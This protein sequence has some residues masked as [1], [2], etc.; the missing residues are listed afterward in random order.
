MRQH[1][2]KT[3][4]TRNAIEYFDFTLSNTHSNDVSPLD[5]SIVSDMKL[6]NSLISLNFI[7]KKKIFYLIIS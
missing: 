4:T 7:F 2:I 5:L 6:I 3:Q 1:G